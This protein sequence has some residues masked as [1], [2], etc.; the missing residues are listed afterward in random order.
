[1]TDRPTA[2]TSRAGSD[3]EQDHNQFTYP[4]AYQQPP[5]QENIGQLLSSK[6]RQK[7]KVQVKVRKPLRNQVNQL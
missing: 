6:L 4:H 1:M 7:A 2:S 3:L 5:R